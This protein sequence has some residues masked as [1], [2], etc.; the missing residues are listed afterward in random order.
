MKAFEKELAAMLLSDTQ[1][2]RAMEQV[3]TSISKVFEAK[4]RQEDCMCGTSCWYSFFSNIAAHFACEITSL[5]EIVSDETEPDGDQKFYINMVHTIDKT[6]GSQFGEMILD[7]SPQ[8]FL[9]Y[10]NSL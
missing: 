6:I 1:E 7:E 10:Y 5:C 4:S 8:K 3:V 9:D 2:I